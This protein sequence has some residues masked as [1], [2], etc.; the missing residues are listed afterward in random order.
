ME[1][2][3]KAK[4]NLKEIQRK[5][6]ARASYLKMLAAKEEGKPICVASAGIPNE[7]M[8]AMDVYPIFPESLAAIS[9]GIGQSG[10]G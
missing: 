7:V 5:L 4:P 6:S 3:E 1:E 2:A 9:A 10:T 8:Y